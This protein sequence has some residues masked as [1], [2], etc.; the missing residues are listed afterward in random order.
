[1]THVYICQCLGGS[2]DPRTRGEDFFDALNVFDQH[3]FE[4]QLQHVG[5]VIEICGALPRAA[6]TLQQ[7][8]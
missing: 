2:R 1:M 5:Y 6:I 8:Q 4:H 3:A 7:H